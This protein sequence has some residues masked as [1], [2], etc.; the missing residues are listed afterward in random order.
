[1][2]WKQVR[3]FNPSKMET[4]KGWCLRN[5]DRGFG[6]TTGVFPSAKADMESQK[7]NGTLH[8]FNTIPLNCAVPVYLDTTSQYEHIEVCDKGTWY[9]DGRKVNAPNASYVFGWGELCDGRRVVEWVN[10]SKKSNEEIAREVLAGKW[11]NGNDRK[12]RL[13]QAGYDY[14]AIQTIVNQLLKPQKKTNEQIAKEV[15]A[16]A[17]GNGAER[18][19]RLQEAG[20][21]YNAIQA[22]VN[23]LV[24]PN[25]KSNE[26]IARDVIAGKWGNGM[27]RKKKLEQAGYN[28]NMVQA[29][30]NRLLR[31]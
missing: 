26:E 29:V 22:I 30:V 13:E 4:Q 6:L 14:N 18:K 10:D 7:K 24:K 23:Q 31:G 21:D 2:S 8:P 28:Y 27:E 15:I 3:A 19:K 12:K 16:G 20:Y 1:M 11:G 5:V 9:S 25:K 17:W